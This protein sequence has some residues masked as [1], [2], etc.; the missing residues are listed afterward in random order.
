MKQSIKYGL[1]LIFTLILHCT[2][3]AAN[4][5]KSTATTPLQRQEK[6]ILSQDSPFQDA[7]NHIYFFYSTQSS[8]LGHTDISNVPNHKSLQL[9]VAYFC[10]HKEQY[11]PSIQSLPP[12]GQSLNSIKHYIFEF[13]KIVV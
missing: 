12:S 9:L 10:E 5:E 13:R 1:L 3:I 2:T 6:C 4:Q 7:L 8:D 11:S